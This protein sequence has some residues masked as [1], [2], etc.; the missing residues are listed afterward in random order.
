M[1][2]SSKQCLLSLF[3]KS[4]AGAGSFA[5]QYSLVD[6]QVPL[7]LT[8]CHHFSILFNLID[9]LLGF[10]LIDLI[11]NPYIGV[12]MSRMCVPPFAKPV[13]SGESRLT[14][15]VLVTMF[16]NKAWGVGVP[17]AGPVWVVEAIGS[18]IPKITTNGCYTLSKNGWFIL[19]YFCFTNSSIFEG[20]KIKKMLTWKHPTSPLTSFDYK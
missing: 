10:S 19:F 8:S 1:A 14:W 6:V 9:H 13:A 7:G 2:T 5:P 16:V 3:A 4:K 15:G 12:Y 20:T 18:T 11:D 17:C